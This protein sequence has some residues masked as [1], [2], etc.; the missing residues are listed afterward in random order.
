MIR[1]TLWLYSPIVLGA[2]HKYGEIE[3]LFQRAPIVHSTLLSIK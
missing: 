1:L 3:P 2:V